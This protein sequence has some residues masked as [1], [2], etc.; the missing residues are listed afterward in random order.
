MYSLLS[1]PKFVTFGTKIRYFRNQVVN[2]FIT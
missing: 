2:F 1:E